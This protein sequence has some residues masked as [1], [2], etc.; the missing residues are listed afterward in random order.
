MVRILT[1]DDGGNDEEGSDDGDGGGG[2][3]DDD[4]MLM[5][6]QIQ[7]RASSL[8]LTSTRPIL[9]GQ[10]ALPLEDL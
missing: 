2:D 4:G 8:G 7:M 5:T 6:V 3:E 10:G 1:K 9:S